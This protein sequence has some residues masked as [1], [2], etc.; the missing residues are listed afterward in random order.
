MKE[1]LNRQV[2]ELKSEIE[3]LKQDRVRLEYLYS[4]QN[5]AAYS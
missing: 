3:S 5:R 2:A 4:L 1:E